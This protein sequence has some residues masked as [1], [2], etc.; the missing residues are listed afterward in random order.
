M[1]ISDSVV[2]PGAETTV[3]NFEPPHFSVISAT[4]APLLSG[5]EHLY[6]M[7]SILGTFAWHGGV[8]VL[9][10]LTIII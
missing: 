6:C 7:G 4:P 10:S 9:V 5:I 2:D 3:C 8:R 1:E